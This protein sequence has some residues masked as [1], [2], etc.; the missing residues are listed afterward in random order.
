DGLLGSRGDAARRLEVMR[1]P[2]L[3]SFGVIAIVLVLVLAVAA[4]S[5]MSPARGLAALVVAGALSRLA[6]LAVISFVPYVRSSG[7]GVAAW[8]SR[9][10]T[11]DLLF[12]WAAAALASALD[13]QRA[14]IALP[15]VALTA[16]GV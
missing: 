12:G 16:V 14:L 2:R 15:F 1:D 3:G 5:S 7:L 9:Y 13:W 10:R 4:M 11:R 6:T 8:D